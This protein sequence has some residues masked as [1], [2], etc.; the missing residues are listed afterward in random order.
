MRWHRQE[1]NEN[2]ERWLIVGLGNPGPRYENTWHNCGFLVLD[3]IAKQAGLQ[4]RRLRCEGQLAEAR[5]NGVPCVL[6]KPLT[7]MNE[8]GR[9]VA[10]AMQYYKIP[11]ERVLVIYDDIDLDCG[12]LR[13]RA[14]GGAGSH[15]GMQ[16]IVQ[17]LQSQAFGRLRVGIGPQPKERDIVD[18]VLAAI[19]AS[20]QATEKTMQAS[21]QRAANC[22]QALLT[23]GYEK[24]MND[25]HR[26]NPKASPKP[27]PASQ[28]LSPASPQQHTAA[29]QQ[30]LPEAEKPSQDLIAEGAAKAKEGATREEGQ[31][32]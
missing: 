5:L 28:Q 9:S 26:Q 1:S 21:F 14:Q 6:L 20:G 19:P 13:L 29:F 22:V 3:E 8:S 15:R 16:S 7:Y 31:D 11:P 12:H 32:G 2:N 24:A 10:A 25:L 23:Q 4:I 30:V 27:T 18:Y 17:H